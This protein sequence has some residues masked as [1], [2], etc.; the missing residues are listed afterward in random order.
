[1]ALTKFD[2]EKFDSN[3]NLSLWQVRILAMLVEHGLKKALGT[4]PNS[5]ED[6]EWVEI[7][8]KALTIIQLYLSNNVLQE[9]LFKKSNA[10]LWSKLENLFLTKSLQISW[11]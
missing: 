1:M 9:L 4:K 5:M 7:D 8:E 10:G 2:I 3:S 11:F 6:D